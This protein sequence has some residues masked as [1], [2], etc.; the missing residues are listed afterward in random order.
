[1][2]VG[3]FFF[4]L[5]ITLLLN[6]CTTTQVSDV[7]QQQINDDKV[8]PVLSIK[9][10]DLLPDYTFPIQSHT[11]N[12]ISIH[13]ELDKPSIYYEG[14]SAEGILILDTAEPSIRKSQIHLF[15]DNPAL[16]DDVIQ[17]LLN[18]QSNHPIELTLDCMEKCEQSHEIPAFLT[19]EVQ[20][21]S[22]L[23]KLQALI[24]KSHDQIP[25]HIIWL[26]NAKP[27]SFLKA[28]DKSY[29]NIT[30]HIKGTNITMSVISL[31]K[32]PHFGL[33]SQIAEQGGGQ[34]LPYQKQKSLQTWLLN[35]LRKSQAKEIQNLNLELTFG[36][37]ELVDSS[38]NLNLT[39]KTNRIHIDSIEQGEQRIERLRLKFPQAK[40]LMK[41]QV[42]QISGSYFD[43]E[44]E[45]Y[46]EI[47]KKF[48][49]KYEFTLN[50]KIA[51]A[52]PN[53]SKFD[54]LANYADTLN[55]SSILIDQG[56]RYE[57]V[58]KLNS[59]HF[60]F[61]RHLSLNEDAELERDKQLISDYAN[62]VMSQSDKWYIGISHFYDQHLDKRFQ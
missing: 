19:D 40:P 53:I 21:R 47:Q 59:L 17:A 26:T 24:L 4:L 11:S 9:T 42:L 20:K 62:M 38:G 27:A 12:S 58:A 61:A 43:S 45:K 13:L 10:I 51:K 33:W 29:R 54:I 15:S 18:I 2:Q 52:T 46:F 41:H 23:E 14:D 55:R 30:K 39:G 3:A 57:A 60:Q 32:N 28:R 34:Y 25:H 56:N 22:P 16:A 1:M 5:F 7:L 48:M 50:S 49:T 6:A 35:D 44:K 8:L 37:A 31:D 36:K